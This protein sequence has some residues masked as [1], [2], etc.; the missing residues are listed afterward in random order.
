MALLVSVRAR[1]A[2]VAREQSEIRRFRSRGIDQRF[3]VLGL[4]VDRQLLNPRQAIE[5]RPSKGDGN[6]VRR[7]F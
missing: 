3:H 5:Q 6:R 7:L 4:G 1:S 2:R